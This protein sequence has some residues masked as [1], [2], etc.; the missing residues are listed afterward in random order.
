MCTTPTGANTPGS[1][2]RKASELGEDSQASPLHTATLREHVVNRLAQDAY[3]HQQDLSLSPSR[4]GSADAS[5]GPS[6]NSSELMASV[7]PAS[8]LTTPL[9]NNSP[10]RSPAP[11]G[12]SAPSTG[13]LATI[14]E[15]CVAHQQP[16]STA[17]PTNGNSEDDLSSFSQGQVT[18][19]PSTTITEQTIDG[20]QWIQFTYTTKGVTSK[21]SVRV[22]IEQVNIEALDHDF[23][24]RTAIY[25]RAYVPYSQYKGNR[26]N[27]ET[28]CNRLAWALAHLNP[29]LTTEKRGILQRAVDS[30]RNRRPDLKSR[31]VVR[32]EKLNNGTL[33]PRSSSRSDSFSAQ[34]AYFLNGG[35]SS[36]QSTPGSSSSKTA[37][38]LFNSTTLNRFNRKKSAS[39]SVNPTVTSH[40]SNTGFPL[41]I[42]TQPG[43][44]VPFAPM[45]PMS[46]T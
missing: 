23:K 29:H 30:Y 18:L 25:P 39:L 10:S 20:I 14:A 37:P 38:S 44:S 24:Q 9:T 43:H 19:A 22:D 31:R 6:V 35:T 12:R 2:K 27:Y 36:T 34:G 16:V 32:Q 1:H 33:R 26:W 41:T 11:E 15:E 28:E 13:E 5:V 42:V 40:Y 8:A 7:D 21:Y 3:H 46:A 4:S 17:S 45:A